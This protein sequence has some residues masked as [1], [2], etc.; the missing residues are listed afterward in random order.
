MTTGC[1]TSLSTRS[2]IP[3]VTEQKAP[4]DFQVI[5]VFLIRSVKRVSSSDSFDAYPYRL[6]HNLT[7]ADTHRQTNT[8]RQTQA[9]D[10]FAILRPNTIWVFITGETINAVVPVSRRFLE[11]ATTVVFFDDFT[12]GSID[13]SKWKHSVT[14]FGGGVRGKLLYRNTTQHSTAQ[15]STAQDKTRQHNTTQR[16]TTQHKTTHHYTTQ[17]NARKQHNTIQQK[18][19]K[20]HNATQHHAR[21]Q[22]NTI[23]HNATQRNTTQR[24]TTQENK[25]T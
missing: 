7:Q 10:L 19:R 3:R 25:T 24:N 12:S 17:H 13:L 23:Q 1:T 5:A 9:E 4:P 14:A 11:R 16:N 21:N 20:Q 18:K 8:G 2:V 6:R 22:N 15:H